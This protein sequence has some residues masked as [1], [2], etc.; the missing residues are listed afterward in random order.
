M[1]KKAYLRQKIS[2]F[3]RRGEGSIQWSVGLFF[4]VFLLVILCA[5]LQISRFQAASLYLEDALAASNLASAL[6]DVEEYGISHRV[7]ISDVESAFRMY[8]QAVKDNLHLNDSWESENG[9]FISG[10]VTVVNYTVYNVGE[11]LVTIHTMGGDG[12]LHTTQSTPGNVRAPNGVPVE[13]TGIYSEISFPVNG[14]WGITVTAHKGK[15]V[16]IVST[17]KNQEGNEAE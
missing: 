8:Q 11:E 6:I 7:Q 12:I 4:L 13:H 1:R 17:A 5:D 9:A 14:L 16:D 10:P 2:F 15:L 3:L